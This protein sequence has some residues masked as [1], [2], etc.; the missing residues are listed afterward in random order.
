MPVN[1]VT[2]GTRYRVL[3]ALAD[4]DRRKR[5][6][7]MLAS[8]MYR[9]SWAIDAETV[10]HRLAKNVFDAII[11]DVSSWN[12]SKGVAGRKILKTASDLPVVILPEGCDGAAAALRAFG[13]SHRTLPW[14]IMDGDL[15]KALIALVIQ[16]HQESDSL[17]ESEQQ[18]A[19]TFHASPGMFAISNP[20]D[21]RHV[22][23]NDSW[24]SVMGYKRNQVIGKTASELG[25][26]DTYSDRARLVRVLLAQGKI[27]DFE[28]RFRTKT[29]SAI[30]V[31]ISGEIIDIR[32]EPHLLLV[33][34]D[35]SERKKNEEALKKSHDELELNIYERTRQLRDEVDERKKIQVALELSEQRVRDMAEAASDWFWETDADGV[36]TYLSAGHSRVLGVVSSDIIGKKRKELALPGE[37]SD[38]WRQHAKTIKAREPFRDFQ[39]DHIRSDGHPQTV[40]ISGKAFYDENGKFV[41]YRGAGANV[42]TQ[43]AAEKREA[44][45]RE[46]LVDAV[47]SIS[48][49]L[50]LFDA[51]DEF[52]MC[53]TRYRK[54]FQKTGKLL[55]PGTPFRKIMKAVIDNDLIVNTSDNPRKWARERL[56]ERK[57]PDP[58]GYRREEQLRDGTWLRF[59]EYKTSDN[60][61]LLLLTNITDLRRTEH[62]LLSAKN[63]AE[64]AS[65]AKSDFLAGMSHE[66][67]TPLNAIIGFSDVMMSE[68]Y[69][70]IPQQKYN[71]YIADIN[72]SG[73]HLLNLINDILDISKIE[74][75]TAKLNESEVDIRRAVDVSI[76]LNENIIREGEI[77]LQKKIPGNLPGLWADERRVNQILLNL[78]SNAAKFTPKGGKVSISASV[79]VSGAMVLSVSDNGIGISP[80]NIQKVMTEF[81]QVDNA[82]ARKKE[83]T[84]LGLPLTRGLVEVHGG[85]LKIE[86]RIGKGTKVTVIFPSSRLVR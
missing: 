43:V 23:V 46:Q 29:G 28:T 37:N 33:A 22:N 41:G 50:I 18:F 48:D 81:G 12:A 64:I 3:V 68:I 14:D 13:V 44:K 16:S 54:I 42:T 40:K 17:H 58:D 2:S 38:K 82:V 52:V 69:G 85:N 53:N 74:S 51:Q 47:E 83:G 84:G 34:L 56:A 6:K 9:L 62:E 32:E 7:S 65:R 45:L 4:A 60:G 55:S 31:I 57:N 21:G 76:R 27:S 75:G 10:E 24:L 49:G 67:R 73:I 15:L 63:Q 5:I 20:K 36:F 39:Y 8:D 86:S 71:E 78:V 26:W 66:L 70:E 19:K 35:I 25:V 1:K 11:L 59:N 80:G 61:R 79:R 77:T 30:D 72:Q